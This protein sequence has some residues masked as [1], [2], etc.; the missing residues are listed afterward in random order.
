MVAGCARSIYE[1]STVITAFAHAGNQVNK[2]IV[3]ARLGQPNRIADFTLKAV[4]PKMFQ[5]CWHVLRGQE[6]IEVLGEAT[7]SSVL[8]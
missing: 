4:F 3:A 5:S 6:N 2:K 8:L 1:R 7:D